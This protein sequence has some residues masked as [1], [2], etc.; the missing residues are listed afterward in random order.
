M[1]LLVRKK[2]SERYITQNFHLTNKKSTKNY[3]E[4][5]NFWMKMDTFSP[6]FSTKFPKQPF[7]INYIFLKTLHQYQ[8]NPKIIFRISKKNLINNQNLQKII[9]KSK[10]TLSYTI[11]SR[12]INFC[13][14][15]LTFYLWKPD[16]FWE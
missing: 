7:T 1:Y 11:Y 12:K 9:P 6:I 15:R 14:R 3:K 5:K 10:K 2:L 16:N 8:Y 13:K 4:T